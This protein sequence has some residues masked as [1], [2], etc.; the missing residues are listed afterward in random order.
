MSDR[1][2]ESRRW[3]VSEIRFVILNGLGLLLVVATLHY[4]RRSASSPAQTARSFGETGPMTHDRGPVGIERIIQR[5][6]TRPSISDAPF[7]LRLSGY[8]AGGRGTIALFRG[9]HG[10]TYEVSVGHRVMGYLLVRVGPDGAVVRAPNGTY[11]DIPL[12]FGD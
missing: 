7:P 4:N 1:T 5:S 2:H 12:S 3:F 10:V 6:T 11:E 8:V 9:S